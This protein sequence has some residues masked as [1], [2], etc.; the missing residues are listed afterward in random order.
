MFCIPPSS[1]SFLVIIY[2][3]GMSVSKTKKKKN[4]FYLSCFTCYFGEK[5]SLIYMTF[6]FLNEFALQEA[7]RTI[8]GSV[9]Y[10]WQGAFINET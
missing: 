7:G 2:V 10:T 9:K 4:F 5:G 6:L 1:F 3:Y 8:E